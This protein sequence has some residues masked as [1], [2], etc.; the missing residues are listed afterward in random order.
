MDFT[1]PNYCFLSNQRVDFRVFDIFKDLLYLIIE[2]M[3]IN[4]RKTCEETDSFWNS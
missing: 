1:N 4:I 2:F 3:M